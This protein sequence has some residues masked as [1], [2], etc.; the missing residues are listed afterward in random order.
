MVTKVVSGV[1]AVVAV[2][3]LIKL[4]TVDGTFNIVNVGEQ[5]GGYLEGATEWIFGY[6][7]ERGDDLPELELGTPSD[8]TSDAPKKEGS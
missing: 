3:A 6:A 7:E 4:A 1:I 5:I 8:P 2:V